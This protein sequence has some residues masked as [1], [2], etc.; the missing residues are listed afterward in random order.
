MP[1]KAALSEVNPGDT[2]GWKHAAQALGEPLRDEVLGPG[3][4]HGR[5]KYRGVA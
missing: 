3:D 4:N 1:R 5:R 2:P